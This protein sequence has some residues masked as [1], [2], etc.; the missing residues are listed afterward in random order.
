MKHRS[1]RKFFS[2]ILT[3]IMILVS[4]QT[5]T[6]ATF[7]INTTPSNKPT[8]LSPGWQFVA[9]SD[10][11]VN[12][13]I[14]IEVH[15]QGDG[16]NYISTPCTFTGGSNPPGFDWSCQVFTGGVPAAFQSKTIEY[17]F[18]VA[19]DGTSCST[20][21][22]GFTGFNWTFTTSPTA[23]TLADLS[24]TGAMASSLPLAATAGASALA[25]LSAGFVAWRRRK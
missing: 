23:I 13:Q 10:T 6:A 19:N 17:Q 14:C 12:D 2:S 21:K 18:F 25:A 20:N 16:G 9:Q 22:Y 3:F 7:V 1:I 15:P 5:L 4:V 8:W 11:V 24:A